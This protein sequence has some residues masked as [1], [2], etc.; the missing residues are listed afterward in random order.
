MSDSVRSIHA[1]L[2]RE[3]TISEIDLV[4]GGCGEAGTN[5]TT[6]PTVCDTSGSTN[7]WDTSDRCDDDGSWDASCD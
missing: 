4:S 3:L 5:V 1:L 7:P 2:A 6:E